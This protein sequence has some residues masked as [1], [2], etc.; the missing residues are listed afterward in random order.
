VHRILKSEICGKDLDLE[1]GGCDNN[2][3]QMRRL[4]G[5][6]CH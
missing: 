4:S 5:I 2:N 3:D 6:R 1:D